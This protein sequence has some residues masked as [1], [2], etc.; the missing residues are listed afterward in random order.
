MKSIL[1]LFF[2]L[3]STSY[4]AIAQNRNITGVV[5]DAKGETLP[6][7]SVKVKGSALGTSTDLDGKYSLSVP[8][9]ST[10][11]I[12]YIG[13]VTKEVAVND[14]TQINIT[15]ESS[16]TS[17]SEVVV[18]ALGIERETKSLTYTVQTVDTKSLSQ[19]RE[20]NVVNSLAGKVAGLNFQ[21]STQGVGGASRVVLRG[22]RSISGSSEPLYIIDGVPGNFTNINPDDVE[23][24]TVLKGPNAAALYGSIASNGAIVVNTK[25]GAD[26]FKVSFNQSYTADLPN[27]L[28]DYQ[29]E[30]GQGTNGIYA[31]QSARNWGPKMDGRMVDHWSNDP[32]WTGPQQ[33]AFLPQPDNIR[34]FFQTGKLSA[35]NLAISTGNEKHQTYFSYTY[36]EG[37]GVVRNNDINQHNANLRLNN[38]LGDKLTLDSKF[39]YAKK[40]ILNP[41]PGFIN[42]ENQ[43]WNGYQIL[44]NLRT[45]DIRK[46]E[47]TD[48]ATGYPTR[49]Y[50]NVADLDPGNA[51]G[52]VDKIRN[53]TSE[54]QV[55][56]FSTL[57]YEFSKNLSAF[58]RSSLVRTFGSSEKTLQGGLV[59]LLPVTG[60]YSVGASNATRLD[61]DLLVSYKGKFKENFEFNANLGASTLSLRNSS[62]NSNTGVALTVQ[63]FYALSNTQQV[64][65]NYNVGSPRDMSSVYGFG[66]IGYKGIIYL[67]VTGRN[68]WSSTLP[69]DN[70]SYFYPSVG[71]TTIVSDI[72]DMPSFVS[73]AKLK[74]SYAEVGSSTSAFQLDR[75]ASI[76]AG[77]YNGFLTLSGTIPNAQLKPE[78]TKG[79][80]LGADVRFFNG[81]LGVDFTYYKTNTFNQLFSISLPPASGASSFF[82]NGGDVQNKGIELMLNGS[83]LSSQNGLNWDIAVNFSRNV[84]V[85]QKIHDTRSTIIL[86]AGDLRE[87]R[88][89]AGKRWGEMYVRGFARDAQGS[90]IVENSGQPRYTPGK[91]VYAGNSEPDWLA[92]VQNSL[93]YKRFNFSFLIDIRQGGEIVSYTNS[94]LAAAGLTQET[95]AGREGTLVFGK[96][97]F[98]TAGAVRVDGTPNNLPINVQGFW[99]STGGRSAG[100]VGEIHTS[101]ASNARLRELTFGYSLPKKTLG[102]PVNI[103]LTGRNVFFLYNKA[104]YIDPDMVVG[105]GSGSQ[106]DSSFGPPTTRSLGINVSMSF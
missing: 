8:A 23:S 55:S 50:W 42:Y 92:G 53:N 67:D 77:G 5:S 83:P 14:Q 47:F 95:A 105:I 43:M 37:N 49:H 11:V 79:L 13:Y 81:R 48:P 26:G 2:V 6:G 75:T 65:S 16:E 41:I 18:T 76:A 12:A 70:W 45:E 80:E 60:S 72:I 35:S 82:T 17:L 73:F 15:L 96:D 20:F 7:V 28:I 19:A 98:T 71:L 66:Q 102:V 34:D 69:R 38:K 58:V 99:E 90:I 21:T 40:N 1:L 46:Y 24:I 59:N 54:D 3:F 97:F 63:N 25:K 44:R 94:Q 36:T 10:L 22:N 88:V 85:V 106:G 39:S 57:K 74:A 103:A 29:N 30:Y 86:G 84:G 32:N 52:I 4:Y 33:Y 93:S 56:A 9:N 101:S 61:N 104:Q 91:T 78:R 51:Y 89:E 31:K 68:D 87:I 62:T 64:L 100:L 27:I